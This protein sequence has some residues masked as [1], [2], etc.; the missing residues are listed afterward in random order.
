MGR[1]QILIY[2]LTFFL[3]SSCCVPILQKKFYTTEYGSDRPVRNRFK[4]AKNNPNL[5][6]NKQLSRNTVFTKTDSIYIKN[7]K[8]K[9]EK[10]HIVYSFLRFFDNGQFIDGTIK[11][12]NLPLN[13]YNNLKSGIIG[14][15][16][17]QNN[18]ILYEYFLVTAHNC[19]DYY[20]TESRIIG[21]S[22][23]GYQ[24]LKIEGLTG[25]PDW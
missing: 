20:K 2:F 7:V 12:L 9:K 3:L 1:F 18:K 23:V 13:D 4:S 6:L 10:L 15:Y 17:I 14:Y 24:K 19:G 21:D 22:I 16:E 5:I 25:T 8:T 11:D